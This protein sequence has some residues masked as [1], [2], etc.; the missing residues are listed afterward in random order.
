M[1][2]KKGEIPLCACK[3]HKCED[4]DSFTD[5]LENMVTLEPPLN[6]NMG[7]IFVNTLL[8][9][10]IKAANLKRL[11]QWS[12]IITNSKGPLKLFFVTG[13][14]TNKIYE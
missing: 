8:T 12:L 11:I 2:E 7:T 1:M 10:I 9:C 13:V 6:D 3:A 14:L 4:P 5:V